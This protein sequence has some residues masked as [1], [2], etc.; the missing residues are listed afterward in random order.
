MHQFYPSFRARL[1][2]RERLTPPC[3]STSTA[4]PRFG[5]WAG[6]TLP[7]GC[8]A[9][10]PGRPVPRG[11]L[12]LSCLLERLRN[13]FVGGREETYEGARTSTYF[14]GNQVHL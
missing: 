6:E 2:R 3:S 1:F 11:I 13:A 4:A 14:G 9:W 5:G 10:L 12:V 8:L 7:R